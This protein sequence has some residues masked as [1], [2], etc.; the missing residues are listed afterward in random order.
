VGLAFSPRHARHSRRLTACC[1]PSRGAVEEIRAAA[2]VAA[3]FFVARFRHQAGRRAAR[4]RVRGW[5]RASAI[6]SIASCRC[7]RRRAWGARRSW[8]RSRRLARW[9]ARTASSR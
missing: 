2:S 3:L 4:T 6:G 5:R 9:S 7:R 1:V 8:R